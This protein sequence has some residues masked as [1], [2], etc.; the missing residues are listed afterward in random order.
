MKKLFKYIIYRLYRIALL[1][2]ETLFPVIG[3]LV[4]LSL[5]EILHL[6]IFG[7]FSRLFF[8]NLFSYQNNNGLLGLIGILIL[9]GINYLFLV[10]N[11]KLKEIN[12]YFINDKNK[13]NPIKGNLI[14]WGY[15]FVLFT[16][17]FFETWIYKSLH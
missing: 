14:F 8:N 7:V 13:V 9:V 12:D 2:E 6:I 10:R 5:L 11:N 15:L 4:Y 3:F 16:I 1:Q 17:M